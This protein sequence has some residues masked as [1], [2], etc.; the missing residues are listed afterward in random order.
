MTD[1][2]KPGATKRDRT[3]KRILDAAAELFAESGP[4]E[5][6]VR[7][8]AARA[9]VSHALVHRYFGSKDELIAAALGRAAQQ[10]SDAMQPVESAEQL[11]GN[12]LDLLLTEPTI[13]LMAVRELVGRSRIGEDYPFPLASPRLVRLIAEGHALDK[14][15]SPDAFDPRVIVA[16]LTALTLGWTALEESLS[17][18]AGLDSQNLDHERAEVRRLFAHILKLAESPSA[19]TPA[20]GA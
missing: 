4:A 10:I 5:I 2:A 9:G 6:S 8:V 15:P 1:P 3:T 18:A 12:L 19:T 17:T 13:P 11:I 16:S 20:T 7:D 14:E